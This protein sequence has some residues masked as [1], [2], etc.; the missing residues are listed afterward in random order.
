[1]NVNEFVKS[2]DASA[3]EYI[4]TLLNADKTKTKCEFRFNKNYQTILFCNVAIIRIRPTKKEI[5]VELKIE[6]LESYGL[7][8][9]VKLKTSDPLWGI[10]SFNDDILTKILGNISKVFERCYLS[11]AVEPFGCCSRYEECSDKRTC[12]HP[13]IKLASGCYYKTNLEDERIFYGKNR[14]IDVE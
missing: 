2:I 6:H 5:N 1:M 7:Q 4:K 8:D 11:E 10:A 9:E 12:I 3:N 14:N 13:D